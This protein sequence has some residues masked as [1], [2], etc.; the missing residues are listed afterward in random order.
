MS[1][2]FNQDPIHKEASAVGWVLEGE[3]HNSMTLDDQ[4][5]SGEKGAGE[6]GQGAS[7]VESTSFQNLK[8]KIIDSS[9]TCNEVNKESTMLNGSCVSSELTEPRAS[10]SSHDAEDLENDNKR[11][12]PVVIDSDDEVH[13]VDKSVAC[14]SGELSM[15]RISRMRL[16]V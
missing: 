10:K 3:L 11:S 13:V 9:E 12:Q 8:T 2:Y 14:I 4:L 5:T 15:V 7:N 16:N 6:S 1:C